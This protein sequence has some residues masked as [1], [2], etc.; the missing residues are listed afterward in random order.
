MIVRADRYTPSLPC[1]EHELSLGR[2]GLSLQLATSII[3]QP[4]NVGSWFAGMR[5]RAEQPGK[6]VP[7]L[8]DAP[9]P[10]RRPILGGRLR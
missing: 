5:Y 6:F 3:Q 1:N 7:S 2:Q 9:C 10:A 4:G 8:S